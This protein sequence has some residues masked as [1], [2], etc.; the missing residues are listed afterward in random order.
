MYHM[1]LKNS[2]Y[3][4]HIASGGPQKFIYYQ[5]GCLHDYA[6]FIIIDGGRKLQQSCLVVLHKAPIHDK[7]GFLADDVSQGAVERSIW[8]LRKAKKAFLRWLSRNVW[9]CV[10]LGEILV[11]CKVL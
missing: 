9:I 7:I 2:K 4:K 3:P 6:Q 5:A 1:Y 8:S 11:P 10:M